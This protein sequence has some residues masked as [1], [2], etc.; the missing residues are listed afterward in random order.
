L[1]SWLNVCLIILVSQLIF[2]NNSVP[3]ARKVAIGWFL[4]LLFV[5]LCCHNILSVVLSKIERKK[6]SA[7]A[8][9]E[10]N[11]SDLLVWSGGDTALQCKQI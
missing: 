10:V 9:V 4:T 1:I 11:E 8:T 5:I 2:D 6:A 3:E 7:S